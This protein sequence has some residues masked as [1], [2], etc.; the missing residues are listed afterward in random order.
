MQRVAKLADLA[1]LVVRRGARLHT[2][3]ARRQIGK[4]AQHSVAAQTPGNNY[5]TVSINTVNLEH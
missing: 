3:E 5:L 4:K 2:D 1:R